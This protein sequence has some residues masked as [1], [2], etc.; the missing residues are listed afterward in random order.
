M[1]SPETNMGEIIQ[2]SNSGWVIEHKEEDLELFFH[3]LVKHDKEML[4]KKG[5]NAKNYIKHNL[6]WDKI[7]KIDYFKL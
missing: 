6:T 5:I 2:N 3:D 4:I 1:V 7:A